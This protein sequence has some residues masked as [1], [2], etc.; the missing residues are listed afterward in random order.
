MPLVSRIP[1]LPVPVQYLKYVLKA[2]RLQCQVKLV[3]L[4]H[5]PQTTHVVREERVRQVEVWEG[6]E[7]G[8]TKAAR[9]HIDHTRWHTLTV[10]VALVLREHSA[11]VQHGQAPHVLVAGYTVQH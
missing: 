2:H 5:W 4:L 11:I 8:S 9:C 10:A 3:L 7:G 6:S 1:T